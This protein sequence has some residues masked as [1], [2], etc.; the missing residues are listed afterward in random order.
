MPRDKYGPLHDHLAH[1][2]PSVTHHP[3][4][5]TQIEQIIGSPLPPSARNHL[6]PQFWA[7]DKFGRHVQANA[8]LTAD[9]WREE[10]NV[11]RER[12]VFVRSSSE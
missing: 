8:W 5:F 12:I 4:T 10:L 1:L 7:N 3:L 11:S 6:A 9:W 2:S